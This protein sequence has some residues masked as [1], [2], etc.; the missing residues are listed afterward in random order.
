MLQSR[1]M[2]T[3]SQMVRH[4]AD[5]VGNKVRPLG[6]LEVIVSDHC[7]ITC[8]QCNHASPVIP[9][10]NVDASR[11]VSDCAILAGVFAPSF[12]KF[13]GGEPL[14]NPELPNIISGVRQ[15]KLTDHHI[16]I[17]NGLLLD[18]M[19]E[20]VWG[21]IDEIEISQYPNTK[22]TAAD[23]K[24][25][26]AKAKDHGVKFTHNVYDYFRRTFSTVKSESDEMT[27]RVFQAC[28]IAHVWG[29]HALYRGRLYRCP[30]SIYVPQLLGEDL[31]EGIA[32]SERVSLRTEILDF[33]NSEMP[34]SSCSYCVGTSGVKEHHKLL[35]RTEW[36]DDVE[37]PYELNID[38][39][40][41]EENL[42]LH[43]GMDDCKIPS[44]R[45][46]RSPFKKLIETLGYRP[47]R[48]RMSTYKRSNRQ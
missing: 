44:H 1:L 17:T 2:R 23:I 25:Y 14:L 29:C 32:I 39:A 15:T 3:S 8:R 34:L 10:W 5:I 13:L 22:L 26:E 36:R 7:N 31:G 30:Q 48:I 28:K 20:D 42:Q 21:L 47:K 41:L 40:L 38:H 11:I 37:R 18:R 43:K 4:Q 6:G 35:K 45:V 24:K 46:H 27:A 9:K 16:L 12:I 33:L 19:D